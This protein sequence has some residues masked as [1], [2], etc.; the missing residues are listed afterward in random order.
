MIFK[1][2]LHW[3]ILIAL[4]LAVAF[5]Y[6]LPNQIPYISWMGV[7]FL[8]AL[9]MIVVPLILSSIISGVASVGGGSNLGRIG[10]KTM[11]FYVVTSLIAILV[12]LLLVNLFQPGVGAT[13]GLGGAVN[14]LPSASNP[15]REF[16]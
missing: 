4:V 3:Q 14:T 16:R 9:N 5:G 2:N 12:G 15:A 11:V 8:R 10:A 1:I 13:L 7:V 6:Y